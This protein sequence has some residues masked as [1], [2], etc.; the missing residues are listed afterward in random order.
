MTT[1]ICRVFLHFGSLAFGSLIIA[2]ATIVNLFLEYLAAKM[3]G[4]NGHENPIISC[5]IKC[6]L[7][8]TDCFKRFL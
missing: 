7:C 5:T 1:S 6:I 4:V 3:E 8:Y 2:I